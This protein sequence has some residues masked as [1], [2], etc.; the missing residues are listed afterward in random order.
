MTFVPRELGGTYSGDGDNDEEKDNDEDGESDADKLEPEDT[1][2]DCLTYTISL[3]VGYG[4]A[5]ADM[6]GDDADATAE[7]AAVEESSESEN[8]EDFGKMNSL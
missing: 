5:V 4:S 6:A 1:N 8:A 3:V 2:L 7:D